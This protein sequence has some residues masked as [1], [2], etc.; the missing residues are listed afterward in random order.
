MASRRRYFG[1]GQRQFVT[2]SPYR[3]A[4]RFLSPRLAREFV[5]ALEEVRC[6]FGF[7]LLDCVLIPD[8]FLL[9]L[10]CQ[11]ADWP[12]SSWRFYHRKGA[13]PL[14]MDRLP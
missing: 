1:P 13:F 14:R 9:I 2:A 11:P 5:A 8:H 12:W 10:K 4:P 6:E 7:L 3:R